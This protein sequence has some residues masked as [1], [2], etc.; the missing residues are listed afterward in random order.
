M[1]IRFDV[2]HERDRRALRHC[3]TA[4]TAFAS[5]PAVKSVGMSK[6]DNMTRQLRRVRRSLDIESTATL[7]HAFVTSRLDYC[8]I[9]LA[10]SP[11]TVI[12]KLQRE[13]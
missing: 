3:V 7:V 1:F 8:N 11:K 13:L 5:H 2:I 9:L 12:D 6:Y 4:K 10:G